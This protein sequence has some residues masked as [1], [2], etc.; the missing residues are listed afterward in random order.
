[1]EEDFPV[2]ERG[3]GFFLIDVEGRR[4]LDGVSSLWCNV[5]GHRRAEIDEAVRRQLER[6]A[7]TTMLGLSHPAAIELAE[8]LVAIAPR[9]SGRPQL[10]RVFYSDSGSEAMEIA[11]KIAFQYG[12]Q[13]QTEAKGS[14]RKLFVTLRDAYHGDTLGAVSA[15]GIDLF[16]SA[17]RPLLFETLAVPPRDGAGLE[18]LLAERGPEIAAVIVEPLVQGA[19]GIRTY[20]PEVLRRVRDLTRAHGVLL[21]ADEVATGFGRTGRMFAC[22]HAGVVPDLM[23]VAKGLTG[24]Y[25]PLAATLATER[26]YEAFLGDP[27]EQKTFF[28]G[29]TYTGNPLACAAAAA[30]LDLIGKERLIEKLP[31]KIR[32][33]AEAL[34]RFRDLPHV[35]EIRHCGMMAGI[36]LVEDKTAARPYP[37][38]ARM[39]HRVILEARK[40]G[41]ILRPLGNTVVLMPPPAID[42]PVLDDL[43]AITYD[44]IAAATV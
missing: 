17:Y 28:H 31:E 22:E 33:L 38:E 26:V 8:R 15:G 35:G 30:T 25:L 19:A 39:G 42:L 9:E 41:A 32:A 11:I 10:S 5:F 36:D 27:V 12:R 21:I 37:V 4:Y 14:E 16:H 34:R 6:V 7:H 1:M 3:D 44:S 13:Q 43:L 24:G 2:I 23:T 20:P 40:R 29:H 18:R